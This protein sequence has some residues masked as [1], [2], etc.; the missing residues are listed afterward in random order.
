M[1]DDPFV[2]FALVIAIVALILARKAINQVA[3]ARVQLQAIGTTAA[4]ATPMPPPLTPLEAF[5]QTLPPAT[6]G[7]RRLP[8]SSSLTSSPSLPQRP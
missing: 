4:A 5:E 2:F 1:F 6:P 3:E 7:S 8:S